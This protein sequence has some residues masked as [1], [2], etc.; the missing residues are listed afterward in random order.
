M[1][2]EEVMLAAE[3]TVSMVLL[4]LVKE[5]TAGPVECEGRKLSEDF[6]LEEKGMAKCPCARGGEEEAEKEGGVTIRAGQ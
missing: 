2:E 6:D 5:E 3:E 1:S 4:A